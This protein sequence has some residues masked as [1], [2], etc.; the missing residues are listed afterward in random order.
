MTQS[1]NHNRGKFITLEGGEG[2]GKSTN[3]T[4][5]RTWLGG[6]GKPVCATR[7][8]GG[9]GVGEKIR[10]ILLANEPL[11]ATTELLL[12]V[13]ARAEHIERV[14]R[15]AL[16][17]G[18]WVVSDRFCDASYAY[19]GGGRGIATEFI[20]ALTHHVQQELQPDLTLLL[21]A[22]VAIGMARARKRQTADRFETESHVFFEK[23]RAAYLQRAEQSQ[24]RIRVI[25]ATQPLEQVQQQIVKALEQLI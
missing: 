19:Q 7:E 17:S 16:Q 6:Q 25:D 8:P 3:L 21:D 14:I 2:V 24:G 23:V 15:P 4:F 20:D 10:A 5:I 1:N 22:P 18:A 9:T 12:M 13:A 11:A